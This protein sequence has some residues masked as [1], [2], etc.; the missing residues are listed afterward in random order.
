MSD[1]ARYEDFRFRD[2]LIP[3]LVDGRGRYVSFTRLCWLLGL[4]VA[5]E[6]GEIQARAALAADTR[7]EFDR[8][9]GDPLYYIR[10]DAVPLWLGV[11]ATDRVRPDLRAR[12]TAFVRELIP[13]VYDFTTKGVAIR[14]G[15]PLLAILKEVGQYALALNPSE[16]MRLVVSSTIESELLRIAGRA[17]GVEAP[18]T[19]AARCQERRLKL[20]QTDVIRVGAFAAAEYRKRTGRDPDK[21]PQVIDGAIRKVNSYREADLPMLDAVIDAYVKRF[22]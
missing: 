21:S 9:S 5:H 22:A 16:R 14:D 8:A 10:V 3:L 17:G 18:V 19:V 15:T 1:L 12:H 11:V 7:V 20:T 13:A 2:D 6:W 4:G